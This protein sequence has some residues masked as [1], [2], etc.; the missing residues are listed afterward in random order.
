MVF[1]KDLRLAVIFGRHDLVQDPPISRV[2]I[3]VCR[4]TL[5]YFNADTQRRILS[6][7]HFAL[8]EG[9]C[10]FLGKSEALVSRIGLFTPVDHKRQVFMKQ[11]G[12]R[13]GRPPLPL[14]APSAAP[15]VHPDD[16]GELALQN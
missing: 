3:L 14:T 1:R 11:R 5:M 2:D 9:G 15:A 12:A 16:L 13:A 10:L 6:S 4:N 7:F 8:S